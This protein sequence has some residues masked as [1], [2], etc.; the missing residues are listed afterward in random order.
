MITGGQIRAGRAFAKLSA[1]ELAQ[2]AHDI[3][4]FRI[5]DVRAVLLKRQSQDDDLRAHDGAPGLDQL[6]ES[7][8]RDVGT[9]AVV[10]AATSEDH[11]RV[12]A[13]HLRLVSQIVRIHADAMPTHET[14]P[15]R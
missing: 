11:L 10:D 2:L 15:K 14:G 4:H 13:E 8:L 3:G 9:H 6:L 12:I 7:L 1:A 5:P